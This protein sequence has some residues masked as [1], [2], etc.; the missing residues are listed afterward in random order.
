MKVATN[1]PQ[2]HDISIPYLALWDACRQA[3]LQMVPNPSA[4]SAIAY[5]LPLCCFVAVASVACIDASNTFR[6]AWGYIGVCS[7]AVGRSAD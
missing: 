1:F 6:D 2:L 7:A 5:T 4:R 3:V